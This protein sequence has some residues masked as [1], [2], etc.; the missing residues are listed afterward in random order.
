MSSQAVVY[1]LLM[2]T[3]AVL[4]ILFTSSQ[5]VFF[6]SLHVV[7]SSFLYSLYVVTSSFTYVYY[8]YVCVS[9]CMRALLAYHNTFSSIRYL[10]RRHHCQCSHIDRC[11]GTRAV[12]QYSRPVGDRVNHRIRECL[13]RKHVIAVYTCICA[14]YVYVPGEN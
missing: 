5:A 7:S 12:V 6:Y 10:R 1:I 4:N 9:E 8:E 2:S 11:T 14:H 3:Q 13:S